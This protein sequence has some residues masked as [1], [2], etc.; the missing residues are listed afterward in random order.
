MRSQ[1]SLA[2]I[3]FIVVNVSVIVVADVHEEGV[4]AGEGFFEKGGCVEFD[5]ELAQRSV[6]GG[7]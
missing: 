3:D 7:W 1:V 2:G 4:G 5:G 6:C